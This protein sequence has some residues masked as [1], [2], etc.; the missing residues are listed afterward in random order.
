MS[1][2]PEAL[3]KDFAFDTTRIGRPHVLPAGRGVY[4]SPFRPFFLFAP[5]ALYPSVHHH[6]GI[7]LDLWSGGWLFCLQFC[8]KDA[9]CRC[10]FHHAVFVDSGVCRVSVRHRRRCPD[11]QDH[12]RRQAG[13][14]QSP[15]LH[16]GMGV[17]CLR[18]NSVCNW[19]SAA[20]PH[21]RST[22]CPRR[23][24]GAKHPLRAD[25][26]GCH[27]CLRTSI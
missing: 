17:P 22:G 15:V 16:A 27:S 14:S 10:E 5:S 19:F 9:L 24:A 25:H 11:R 2:L 3:P 1:F 8:R 13:R 12:G 7:Y 6:A 20:A 21:R 4:D 18:H 26:S 23:T